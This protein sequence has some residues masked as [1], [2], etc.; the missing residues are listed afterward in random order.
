MTLWLT[1]LSGAGKT[2]VA[3]IV[4]REL[5]ARGELVEVLDGD[6]VRRVLAE[7]LGFSRKDR[8]TNAR[9]I[10]YVAGL[11]SRNGVTVIAAVIS[12]YRS[13]RE[14]ARELIA[15]RFVEVYVRASVQ[16]CARRDV[17]GL[18]RRAFAGELRHFTGVSDPYEEPDSPELVLDT[19]Q[20][21][22]EQ[23]AAQVLDYVD[24][25]RGFT[26]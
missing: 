22:P 17:K 14:Q 1:G 2:T 26:T 25:R 8:E 5:R 6:L 13:A 4:E 11:L 9:R 12:P 24:R 20:Q 10:A 3:R 15:D 23:S 19:E 21:T 16:E 7:D 18:Y